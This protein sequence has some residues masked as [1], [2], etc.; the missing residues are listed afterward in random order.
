M[1]NIGIFENNGKPEA[2]RW[3]DYALGILRSYG[4]ECAVRPELINLLDK[5]NRDF[6]K[7]MPHEEFEKFADVVISFGGDGTM[8]SA[9][10]I[11]L[12]S[13]IPIM[14]INVGKLGFLAEFSVNQLDKSLNDLMKGNYRVVDRTVLETDFA[15]EKIFSLNDFVIEKK[16]SSRMITLDGFVNNHFIGSLRADGLIITTPTGSTAYSLSC[17]GPIITPATEVICITPISPHSLT[18]RPLVIPDSSEVM[19]E[20]SSPTGDASLVADG[21]ISKIVKNGDK[22]RIRKSEAKVKLIKPLE[23]SYFDLIRAKL[24]WAVNVVERD[25]NPL[26]GKILE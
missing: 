13:D 10:R 12:K 15:D 7:T 25:E 3:I 2:I 17:G 18:L 20:V 21:Q 8:L 9:A 5:R 4:S 26:D 16:D 6:V 19:L 11:M 14:G 24:L 22:V 1:K 23:S